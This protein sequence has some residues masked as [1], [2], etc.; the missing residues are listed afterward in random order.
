[1]RRRLE[2]CVFP[3]QLVLPEQRVRV[4]RIL[5]LEPGDILKL[6]C[7]LAETANLLI[8]GKLLFTAH[9]VRTGGRR[10]AQVDGRV[11]SMNP[12]QKESA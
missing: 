5:S 10:A 12:V 7:S 8:S 3:L 9:P 2:H 6:H 4:S 1:M 11:R